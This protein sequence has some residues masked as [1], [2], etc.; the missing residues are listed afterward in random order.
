MR[1]AAWLTRATERFR[2]AVMCDADAILGRVMASD[3][4][5]RTVHKWDVV[6]MTRIDRRKFLGL[7]S[8][9]AIGAIAPLDRLVRIDRTRF[10]SPAFAFSMEIPDG[11]HPWTAEDVK[12]NR[13]L[14]EYVEY[15]RNEDETTPTPLVAFSRYKEPCPQFNPGVCIYGDRRTGWM[16][17]DLTAFTNAYVEY[18][19]DILHD[20]Q[21]TH[22]AKEAHLPGCDSVKA[23]LIYDVVCSNGFRHRVADE[24]LV[25]FH[26]NDL[27]LFQFH[28]SF[29][30]AERAD[31]EFASIERTLTFG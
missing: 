4:N 13:E 3:L 19:A 18:F 16:G 22:F 14:Q 5:D 11:W 30:D 8:A 15:H 12:A 21:V 25:V 6:A 23:S 17:E 28:Q 26:Q 7:F 9:A 10:N 1:D 20:S 31:T 2:I 27:L 24:L 29:A